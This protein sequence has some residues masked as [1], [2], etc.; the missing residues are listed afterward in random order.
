MTEKLDRFAKSLKYFNSVSLVSRHSRPTLVKCYHS[1]TGE[2]PRIIWKLGHQLNT[3]GVRALQNF[4]DME[5][6]LCQHIMDR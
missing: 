1:K 6:N 2:L 3:A 5:I 4:M